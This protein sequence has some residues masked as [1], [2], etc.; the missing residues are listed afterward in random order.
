[1]AQLEC[2]ILLLGSP[3]AGKTTVGKAI[4]QYA[5]NEVSILETDQYRKKASDGTY[6]LQVATLP[7]GRF[8]VIVL[9]WPDDL[10]EVVAK[11]RI[12]LDVRPQEQLRRLQDRLKT[13]QLF[14]GGNANERKQALD[15]ARGLRSQW[16]D[17]KI[18]LVIN[19]E[20]Y[21]PSEIAAILIPLLVPIPPD[22]SQTSGEG[23]RTALGGPL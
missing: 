7:E 10:P 4:V 21:L 2:Q 11:H 8:N 9:T 13:K 18:D 3:G 14:F 15:C 20:A 23:E 12:L 1:M 22:H 19:T 6:P 16:L 17:G 5:S